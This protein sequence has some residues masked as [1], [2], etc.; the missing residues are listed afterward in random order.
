MKILSYIYLKLKTFFMKKLLMMV[1]TIVPLITFSQTTTW[2]GIS[3]SGGNPNSTLNVVI[4]G[5]YTVGVST[6]AA[7][8]NCRTIT[9]N[10]GAIFT[11]KS[12][13]YMDVWN[14]NFINNGN[15]VFQPNTDVVLRTGI[16]INNSGASNFIFEDSSAMIQLSNLQQTTPVTIKRNTK[17]VKNFEY[18]YWSSPIASTFTNTFP[19]Q[20]NNNAVYTYQF[21]TPLPLNGWILQQTPSTMTLGKGYAIRGQWCSPYPSCFATAPQTQ[22]TMNFVGVPNNGNISYTSNSTNSIHL[23]GNPYPSSLDAVTFM[24]D[25]SGGGTRVRTLYFWTH[26]TVISSTIPG[27]WLYNYTQD[28]YAIIN[29][30]GATFIASP[31]PSPISDS[32]PNNNTTPTGDIASGQG[33]FVKMR[34]PGSKTFTFTNTQRGYLPTSANNQFYRTPIKKQADRVWIYMSDGEYLHRNTLIAYVDGATNEYDDEYEADVFTSSQAVIYSVLEQNKLIIQGREN[35]FDKNEKVQIGYKTFKAGT[36]KIGVYKKEGA[37]NNLDV[38]L[39]DKVLNTYHNIRET[40]YNYTTEAGDFTNRF[41]ITYESRIDGVIAYI[42]E[43]KLIVEAGNEI[44]KIQVFDVTGRLLI[45]KEGTSNRGE[46]EVVTNQV[47]IVKIYTSEGVFSKK[48]L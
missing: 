24:L 47:L 25:N 44:K 39:H 6:P 35:V 37:F 7:N 12:G 19:P 21:P 16:V 48:L 40:P 10:V 14:G 38:I 31:A 3:W 1:L 5:N 42:K 30:S 17:P 46:Y 29:R 11:V 27:N 8:L 4:N 32:T 18:T 9:I 36:Y 41:E 28:D 34:D 43:G 45:D 23:L 22:H 13:Y 20:Q 2:N 26:N 15:V 33:F